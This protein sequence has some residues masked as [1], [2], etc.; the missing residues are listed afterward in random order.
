[1]K[2]C[3]NSELACTFYCIRA[4]GA[5]HFVGMAGSGSICENL[6]LLFLLFELPLEVQIKIFRENP[7]DLKDSTEDHLEILKYL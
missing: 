1:M 6:I 2:G 4:E 3:C 5:G 7:Y